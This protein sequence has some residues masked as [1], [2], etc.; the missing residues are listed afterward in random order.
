MKR[1]LLLLATTACADPAIEMHLVLPQQEPQMDLSCITAVN[2][3]AFGTDLGTANHGA[4][5]KSDCVDLP[6]AP[7]S[8]ADLASMMHGQFKAPLPSS[9]LLGVEVYAFAGHCSDNMDPYEAMI[10]GGAS[11][12][13]K[14]IAVPL[15]PNISCGA[16]AAYTVH[17]IDLT[18]A[19]ACAP[20]ATG[21]A[22]AADVRPSLIG[23]N[24]GRM[25]VDYGISAATLGADG[26]GQVSSYNAIMGAGC[27][28]AGYND[29]ANMRYGLTCVDVAKPTLCGG[30]PGTV[31]VGVVSDLYYGYYDHE[32]AKQYEAPTFGAAYDI[33]TKHAITG[34]TVT[35]DQGE[36]QV[37]YVEPGPGA[38]TP[39]AAPTGASGMFLVYAKGA[40]AITVA[41]PGQV[42]EHYIVAG[43]SQEPATVIAA[44]PKM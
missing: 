6:H 5:I 31:E 21:F 17:P 41:A 24:F 8:F 38:L 10:Y 14:D 27:I 12:A 43:T 19:G 30:A 7:T 33:S 39:H 20:M 29:S 9:G 28:A 44:L 4:E 11:A 35:I 15:Y 25:Y 42:S 26:T 3:D 34:A 16:K 32:L 22:Y 1:A 40:V 36:G 23:G 13:S 2:L 37:V 18:A